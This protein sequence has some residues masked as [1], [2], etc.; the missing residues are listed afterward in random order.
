[1]DDEGRERAPWPTV[2]PHEAHWIIRLFSSSRYFAAFAVFGTF[3]AA[4]TFYVYGTLV[5]IQL[6]WHTLEEYRISVEGVKHLQVVF[7]EMTDVFLLGTVLFIVAFGLYQF[8]IQP[9]LP[10]PAWLKIQNLDQLTER[11]IEVVGVLLSVTFLAFAVE[12]VMDAS[13]IE[14]GASVAI[15]IAALSLLLVVTHRRPGEHGSGQE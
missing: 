3:L 10:V 13:L 8:F 12:G 15:V 9:D 1:M 6:I 2:P 7:I 5:V 14:F 11:L 4:I